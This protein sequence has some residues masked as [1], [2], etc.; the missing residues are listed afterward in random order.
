MATNRKPLSRKKKQLLVILTG[1]LML[2]VLGIVALPAGTD[3]QPVRAAN[4]DDMRQ[5]MSGAADRYMLAETT[6]ERQAAA[7]EINSIRGG[8]RSVKPG[9]PLDTFTILRAVLLLTI[10]GLSY[11]IITVAFH[12]PK[13]RKTSMV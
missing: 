3:P 4:S 11:Q 10:V 6:E 13:K 2:A 9:S 7:R 5:E 8:S 12:V 1:C